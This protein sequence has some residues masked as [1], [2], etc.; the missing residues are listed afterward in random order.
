VQRVVLGLDPPAVVRSN[1]ND[2]AWIDPDAVREQS[3]VCNG[4][5]EKQSLAKAGSGQTQRERDQ[6]R[7]RFVP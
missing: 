1:G 2:H 5:V 3:F 4:L 7:G 6:K